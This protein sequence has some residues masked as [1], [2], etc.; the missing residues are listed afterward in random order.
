M[1]E[2]G[3]LVSDV[4]RRKRQPARNSKIDGCERRKVENYVK[5]EMSEF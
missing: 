3:Y 2:V 4:S 5:L 1:V